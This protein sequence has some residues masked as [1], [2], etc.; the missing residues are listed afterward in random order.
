ML[1]RHRFMPLLAV[2]SLV[3]LVGLF[4]ASSGDASPTQERPGKARRNIRVES[5]S[6]QISGDLHVRLSA[7][8]PGERPAEQ[9][10]EEVTQVVLQKEWAVLS[11]VE[12]EERVT[13]VYPRDALAYLKVWK[14]KQEKSQ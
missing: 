13:L 11:L 9:Y 2:A 12:D 7:P 6:F 10:F 3:V 14:V 1:T 8:I 5:G 4:V